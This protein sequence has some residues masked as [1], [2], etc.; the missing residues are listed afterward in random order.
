MTEKKSDFSR[1]DFLKGAAGV[2]LVGSAGL[3]TACDKQASPKPEGHKTVTK[4]KLPN[5]PKSKVV[6]IR[7]QGVLDKNRKVNSEVIARMTDDGVTALLGESEA[8]S[9]WARLLQPADILGIKSNVWRFLPTPPGL[10]EVVRQRALGIGIPAE[11]ISVDDRSVL[12]NPVF[13]KATALINMRT[14]R[15]HHWSGVG[16]CIKNY[17]MFSPAP[18]SWHDDSCANLAGVWDLPQVKGKTRLNILVMLTPL[19]HGKGPHHFQAQYTWEYMGLI[20]GTDPVAVDATGVRILEAKRKEYFKKLEPFVTPAKH[21]RVAE[22][23]YGLGVAD[24]SRIEVIKLGWKEGI[25]I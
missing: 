4:Q 6:L 24:P 18:S 21:I 16:S 25:L 17:I 8:A 22:E 12:S 11:Q 13:K 5:R 19:F 3:S 20:I 14:L 7:D 23:K 15:T 1:R 2:V 9:A 10:E